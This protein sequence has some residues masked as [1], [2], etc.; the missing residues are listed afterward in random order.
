MNIRQRLDDNSGV[1]VDPVNKWHVFAIRWAMA[2]DRK[3]AIK[4]ERILKLL[5]D[6]E[7]NR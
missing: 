2:G 4:A 6:Q 5:I 3:R 1:T 7:A